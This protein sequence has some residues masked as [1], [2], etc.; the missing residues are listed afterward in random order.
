M[1]PATACARNAG[2]VTFAGCRATHKIPGRIG[3]DLRRVSHLD[4]PSRGDYYTGDGE[5]ED[6]HEI[7]SRWHGS[8][9]TLASLGLSA[10]RSVGERSCAR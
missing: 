9:Q 4:R 6:E 8:E 10:E 3:D 5:G 1:Q 2:R 7:P